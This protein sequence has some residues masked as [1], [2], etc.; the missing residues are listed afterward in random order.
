MKKIILKTASFIFLL[1]LSYSCTDNVEFEVKS[2]FDFDLNVATPS[3]N[4]S[5]APDVL[6]SADVNLNDNIDNVSAISSLSIIGLTLQLEG[7][8]P[9]TTGIDG[10]SY[11]SDPLTGDIKITI[12]G[13]NEEKVIYEGN[14]DLGTNVDADNNNASKVA[15]V[16]KLAITPIEAKKLIKNGKIT[17]EYS[18]TNAKVRD[19]EF[20]IKVNT[21]I[22]A[23]TSI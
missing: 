16:V 3:Q 22:K 23:I 21:E 19:N 6:I 8:D 2:N 9:K 18:F 5:E 7:Y 11:I 13:N 14:V 12:M 10:D 20:K 4:G 15:P 1:L 17:L